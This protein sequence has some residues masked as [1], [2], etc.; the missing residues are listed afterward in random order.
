MIDLTTQ[1]SSIFL[2]NMFVG[3]FMEVLWPYLSSRFRVL[4][5]GGGITGARLLS[6]FEEMAQ[7]SEYEG[8]FDEYNEMIIQFG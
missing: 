6:K 4:V 8:T 2:L 5:A 3:Q 1:L 7:L